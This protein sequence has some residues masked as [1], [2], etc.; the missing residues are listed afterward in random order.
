[1]LDSLRTASRSWVAKA[2]LILLGVSFA[3]WGVS[4][5]I[6]AP[7]GGNTVM[8]VGDQSVTPQ[9][10][11]LAMQR[12]LSQ[13]SR[14]FGTHLTAEQARAF[15]LDQQVFSQ[16]AA[17]AALDQLAA[18]MRLGL[19]DDR[20]ALLVAD[21][22]AFKN[23]N[24]QFDRQ[25]FSSRLQAVGFDENEYIKERKKIAVRS[26]I[27]DAI[28]DGF[29]PPAVMTDAL[30]QYADETRTLDYLILSYANI[31]PVK[32]P[33]DDALAAWFE[34]AK[35]R[36]RAPEYRKVT[37]VTL[38]P[39][40]VADPGS[41]TDDE[42]QADYDR[43]KDT[44]GTPETRTIEQLTF[45]SKEMADAAAAQLSAREATFDQLVTDQ[46]KTAGDVLLGEFTK[47]QVPDPKVGAAAFALPATGG[48]SPAIQGTFG[49]VILRV[50][51][52]KPATTKTFDEVKE[53]IRNQLA[54]A[55]AS[56]SLSETH[57]RFDDMRGSGAPLQEVANEL[58]L[59]ATTITLDQSGND[60]AGNRIPTLPQSDN[61]LTEAFR[62]EV[63]ADNLPVNLGNTG[64]VWFSVDDVIDER[65][66]PLAEVR[67]RAVA[68]WTSE[69][70]KAALAAK[71][72]EYKKRIDSGEQLATIAGE[73]GITVE[74]KQGL[75]RSSN[76]AIFGQPTVQ[77]AFAGP[78][79]STASALAADGESRVLM[80]VTAVDHQ[81]AAGGGAEDQQTQQ[82]ARAAGD[83]ML[84]Q[85]V[86]RLQQDFGVQINQTAAE[87]ALATMR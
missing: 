75:R 46:G 39:S 16:L 62:A 50:T 35:A 20:L 34:G 61:F 45:P 58:K 70:Q 47:E 13:L 17:G 22:P 65:D 76:D 85:M 33:A 80:K 12:Q 67:D 11:R 64:Y 38:Q 3:I 43:R 41:I 83:D 84:D 86:T 81:P 30:R 44:F 57:D 6:M 26:Q 52:V 31:P 49:A 79:D 87:Q 5:S 77:A 82:I 9:E 4:A 23:S 37:Y 15:G 42:V 29:T 36:Y 48:T 2:L 66:R 51:N 54:L 18:D 72:E 24:G 63:G 14:Q 78:V 71:A 68:D 8:T 56:R 40:D 28:S 32:A 59:K 21:D 60:E 19:S 69:Q 27:V 10:Y 55:A 73:I 7:A 25:L 74:N 53:E 1:M